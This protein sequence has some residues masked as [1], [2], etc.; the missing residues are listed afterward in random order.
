MKS[1]VGAGRSEGCAGKRGQVGKE[2]WGDRDATLLLI[3]RNPEED[4]LQSLW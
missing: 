3:P 4:A 1:K 2:G